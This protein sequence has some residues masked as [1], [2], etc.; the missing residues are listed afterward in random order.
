ML[1]L[2]IAGGPEE[3][4]ARCRWLRRQGATH[5]SF[6][7]PLGPEP[8]AAVDTLGREVLPRLGD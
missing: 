1:R 3:V 6:G 4:L 5:V 7:P 2:G 8:L